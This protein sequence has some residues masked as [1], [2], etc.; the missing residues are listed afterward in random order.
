MNGRETLM[1]NG[2]LNADRLWETFV[3][4]PAFLSWERYVGL[5][6]TELVPLVYAMKEAGVDWWSF[7][8]HGSVSGVPTDDDGFYWHIRFEIKPEIPEETFIAFLPD[9]CLWTRRFEAGNERWGAADPEMFAFE[10]AGWYLLWCLSEFSAGFAVC[11]KME[12]LVD[13]DA[14]AQFLHF[15]DNQLQTTI[16]G[17]HMLRFEEIARTV[18]LLEQGAYGPK[19]DLGS[20]LKPWGW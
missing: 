14:I 2:E 6:Q 10:N 9:V 20:D 18:G 13:P 4:I 16:L 8:V 12:G 7:L 17:L 1:K 3:R 11:H 19:D 5:L 15:A